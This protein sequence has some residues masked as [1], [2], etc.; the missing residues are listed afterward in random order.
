[1]HGRQ[2]ISRIA[3][4]SLIQIEEFF[5]LFFSGFAWG[6]IVVI[7]AIVWLVRTSGMTD[8]KVLWRAIL[9]ATI[10]AS[11]FI[12]LGFLLVIPESNSKA[13]AGC[14][15]LTWG[16]GST[17]LAVAVGLMSLVDS[18]SS[19]RSVFIDFGGL[20]QNI[21]LIPMP[22][23]AIG[24]GFVMT[25]GFLF[26]ISRLLSP[27]KRLP[28]FVPFGAVGGIA[29]FVALDPQTCVLPR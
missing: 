2:T 26:S 12:C 23:I 22:L 16:V 25:T 24:H 20:L 29:G 7:F 5:E 8:I 3:S 9:I 4:K 13:L 6:E 28:F 15:L 10:V 19:P 27:T 11:I 1:M 21:L 14:I 18:Y 17:V